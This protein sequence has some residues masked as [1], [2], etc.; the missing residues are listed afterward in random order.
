[1]L[2]LPPLGLG[3][4][5]ANGHAMVVRRLNP[6]EDKL[7]WSQVPKKELTEIVAYL[8]TLLGRAHRRGQT[9]LPKQPWSDASLKQLYQTSVE[10][11]AK[12]EGLYLAF[13]DLTR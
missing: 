7:D 11:A 8:G 12:H 13:C 1:L 2:K 5:E 9:Q 6:D 4:A 10:L 3:V